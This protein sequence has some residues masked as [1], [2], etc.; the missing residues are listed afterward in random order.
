MVNVPEPAFVTVIVWLN[1]SLIAAVP[2]LTPVGDKDITGCPALVPVPVNAIV[3]TA[4][5]VFAVIEIMPATV[6]DVVGANFAT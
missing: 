1:V 3:E 4:G 6:P 2:K 5:L